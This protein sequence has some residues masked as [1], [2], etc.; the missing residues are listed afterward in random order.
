M[1]I[2]ATITR[3]HVF[4]FGSTALQPACMCV[5]VPRL[6]ACVCV[7]VCVHP[8]LYHACH[9]HA[10]RPHTHTH[11]HTRPPHTPYHTR[12]RPHAHSYIHTHT[13]AHTKKKGAAYLDLPIVLLEDCTAFFKSSALC[14]LV[15]TADKGGTIKT[16][17]PIPFTPLVQAIARSQVLSQAL[18]QTLS[19]AR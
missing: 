9:S 19:L 8:P 10:Q 7:C 1:A 3:R 16:P 5:P 17:A 4:F 14:R 13:H 2:S 12:M 11:P 18:P 15:A 6:C